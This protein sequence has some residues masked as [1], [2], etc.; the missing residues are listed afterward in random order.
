M[1]NPLNTTVARILA[2]HQRGALRPAL[3]LVET[4]LREYPLVPGLFNIRDGILVAMG[5]HTC[6]RDDHRR[7]LVLKPDFHQ[8]LH[9][10]GNAH[11]R[12]GALNQA[13]PSYQRATVVAPGFAPA[14]NNKG[15]TL[16]DLGRWREARQSLIA[17]TRADPRHG[18]AAL[19][20]AN[21]NRD[22]G[23][24]AAANRAYRLVLIQQPEHAIAWNHL[25]IAN[26]ERADIQAAM[27]SQRR[28]L[29]IL[30]D[31][32]EA[33]R[34]LGNL[35]V[36]GPKDRRLPHMRHLSEAPTTSAEDRARLN[37][38]LGKAHD[39]FGDTDQ[40]FAHFQQGNVIRKAVLGYKLNR[41]EALF[42]RI[43]QAF[44]VPTAPLTPLKPKRRDAPQPIF[45]VGMPR[46]GTTL[47]EQ[48]LA[49]HPLVHG[50]GELDNLTRLAYRFLPAATTENND[51]GV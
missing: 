47:I 14:H 8:A 35:T 18:E 9:N 5:Q 27:A 16:R 17:A 23:D 48:I 41:H 43:K 12:R 25:G 20:L 37:F 38:A 51:K 40:A 7:A 46:S 15:G 19:N 49:S 29:A 44:S 42:A 31:F 21:S 3:S 34:H 11:K 39:D 4:L 28:A 50:A 10:F 1:P 33:H 6:A 32:A 24:Y 36:H 30:P 13:L 22:L 26:H 2:L 45:I